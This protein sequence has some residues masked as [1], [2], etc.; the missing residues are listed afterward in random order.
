MIA[1]VPSSRAAFILAKMRAPQQGQARSA[2]RPRQ[3]PTPLRRHMSTHGRRMDA[4]LLCVGRHAAHD[5]ARFDS[6]LE[7][8]YTVPHFQTRLYSDKVSGKQGGTKAASQR[9]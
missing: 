4:S 2:T 3:L 1:L 8:R 9:A 5:R 7:A 6:D